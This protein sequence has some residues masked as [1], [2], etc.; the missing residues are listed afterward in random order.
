M[1][2][3]GDARRR[4]G[5][6]W[7]TTLLLLIGLAFFLYEHSVPDASTEA[8]QRYLFYPQALG[9]G[10][11]L[12]LNALL[13]LY[14]QGVAWWEPIAN[15][16]YLWVLGRKVE[17]ACGPWGFLALFLFC[18][19]GGTVSALMLSPLAPGPFYGLSGVVAGLFGAYFVLFR[20]EPI[21]SWL[22]PIIL[23]RVPA[24]VHLLYWLA[25][26]FG[27]VFIQANWPALQGLQFR[28]I[29]SPPGSNW[30]L[31]GAFFVGL[32]AGQLFARREF[33]YY[34]LLQA[35]AAGR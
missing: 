16:V 9:Y 33:V 23:V 2:P 5:F 10:L 17:D 29:A 31:A 14:I 6:P 1:I 7:M 15:L 20:G 30:P 11:G 27:I 34:R 18:G 22:P 28:Q 12:L 13:C 32:L 4:F 21:R 26:A 25:V 24:A 8:L 19:V 3:I 35:K